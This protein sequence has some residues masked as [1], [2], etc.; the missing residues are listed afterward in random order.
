VEALQA[1]DNAQAA[2]QAIEAL[3]TSASSAAENAD[4]AEKSADARPLSETA[5]SNATEAEATQQTVVSEL[6]SA[7][8]SA[9]QYSATAQSIQEK[10]K[11]IA[12]CTERAKTAETQAQASVKDSEDPEPIAAR[13]ASMNAAQASVHILEKS[14]EL[15]KSLESDMRLAFYTESNEKMGA[16][17]AEAQTASGEAEQ[18]A[19]DAKH[20]AE[21]ER[22]RKSREAQDAQRKAEKACSKARCG[23]PEEISH[24]N[25]PAH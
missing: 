7:H 21:G 10:L 6:Q 11:A 19:R 20:L 13:A 1:K 14:V 16:L 23:L 22:D 25:H 24:G 17:L 12:E 15:S 9:K 5:R 2:L 18:H 3:N 4:S 8:E